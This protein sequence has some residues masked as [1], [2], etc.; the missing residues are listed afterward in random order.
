M[1]IA[2]VCTKGAITVSPS[3]A[4]S[5]A[6]QTM[7]ASNVGTVVVTAS[8][9]DRLVVVGIITDRDIVRAQLHRTSDLSRLA[10][11]EVMTPDP[12]VL[13]EQES[14]ETAINQ[15]LAR[16][17]RRAPVIDASGMLV[18]LVSTDD[19]LAQVSDELVNL[20]QPIVQQAIRKPA[21]A[22]P[23]HIKNQ[24]FP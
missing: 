12:L 1:K 23:V 2:K 5:E 19:L 8:H 24:C 10:V 17:V 20:V 18:G 13:S 16:G 11:S 7:C 3:A 4:L 21:S 6:A 9:A 14:I 15:M 22:Q